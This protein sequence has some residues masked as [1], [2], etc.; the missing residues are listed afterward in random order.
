MS[1]YK[2]LI[3]NQDAPAAFQQLKPEEFPAGEVTIRV[4]YSS[5][6][7]KDGLAVSGKPGVIR[8]Y[9]MVPGIDLAGTVEDSQ[10]PSVQAGR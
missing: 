3:V 5:L 10:I 9:P 7:Y 2:A 1:T 6:N 8:K 4:V